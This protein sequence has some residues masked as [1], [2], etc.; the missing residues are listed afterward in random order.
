M[1][2]DRKTQ[3][4]VI[5]AKMF[6]NIG[7]NRRILTPI[8]EY[9]LPMALSDVDAYYQA[10][11]ISSGLIGLS[12]TVAGAEKSADDAKTISGPNPVAVA[13]VKITAAPSNMSLPTPASIVRTQANRN[14]NYL[15]LLGLMA[16]GGKRN[17]DIDKYVEGLLGTPAVEADAILKD[18]TTYGPL[19][20]KISGCIVLR[21]TG[22]PC[23]TGSLQKFR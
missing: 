21:N 17:P 22:R 4:G 8:A 6:K 9:T 20:H 3:A 10:G 13:N 1:R 19:Y 14:A 18:Q 11:T 7:N 5:Y 15:R 2:A 12:K 23:R 16:P